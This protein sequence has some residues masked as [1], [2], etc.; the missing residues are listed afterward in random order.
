MRTAKI[1][2]YM[3]AGSL[4]ASLLVAAARGQEP[5]AV[6]GEVF[7]FAQASKPTPVDYE[8]AKKQ[9][10]SE[11]KPLVVFV[12][13]DYRQIAGCV[14]CQVYSLGSEYPS[15]CIVVAT[16]AAYEAVMHW[17][18]T[19][20][21]DATDANIRAAIEWGNG[22]QEV[23]QNPFDY[24]SYRSNPPVGPDG[25]LL[26][27]VRSVEAMDELNAQRAR[28]G[29]RPF[30]RH[31]GLTVAAGRA[32]HFRAERLIAGH[33]D[34]FA[35]LPSGSTANA[36]G[37]GAWYPMPNQSGGPTFGT[38]CMWEDWTYAGAAWAWGSDG[39]RYMHLFVSNNP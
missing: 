11:H 33:V 38:C 4:L 35:F 2:L 37:C 32:A 21:K 1:A 9:A 36:A 16:P 15:I 25:E 29:L 27:P 10:L 8:A 26:L 5:L 17:R 34:D 12:G 28:R 39:R 30:L 22:W 24:R 18:A 20:D 13:C 6:G 3:M 31:D 19:L 14:V 7:Y 23:T